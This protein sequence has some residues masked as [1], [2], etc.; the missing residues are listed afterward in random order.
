MGFKPPK[1]NPAK[2]VAFPSRVA[3]R[4]LSPQVFNGWKRFFMDR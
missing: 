4:N 3:R 2:E 1:T